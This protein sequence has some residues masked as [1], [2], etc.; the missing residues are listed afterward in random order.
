MRL[1]CAIR[2]RW[3]A[4]VF[5]AASTVAMS[6]AIAPVAAAVPASGRAI[7]V[8][9]AGSSTPIV[10]GGSST[11]FSLRLPDGAA[12]PGDSAD[13]NYRVQSF[14]VPAT[15]DPGTMRWNDIAPVVNGGWALYDL[16]TNPYTEALTAKATRHGGPGPIINIPSFSFA[17]FLPPGRLPPERYHVGIAC[18]LFNVIDRYWVTD[19]ALSQDA[20]DRPAELHWRALDPPPAGTHSGSSVWFIVGLGGLVLL[21]A[22]VGGRRLLGRPQ[23]R[24]AR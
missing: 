11:P 17:V 24:A 7:M 2:S 10:E 13:G 20:A 16:N 5:A 4:C 23:R 19:I 22:A 8:K 12:C 9:E 21:G 3:L 18:S 15:A 1:A 14:I 6:G